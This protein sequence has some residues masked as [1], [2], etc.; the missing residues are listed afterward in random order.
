[1]AQRRKDSKG[2]LKGQAGVWEGQ[3]DGLK[4]SVWTAIIQSL[5]I[6]GGLGLP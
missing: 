6:I 5:P 4:N 2:E 3:K 1:M